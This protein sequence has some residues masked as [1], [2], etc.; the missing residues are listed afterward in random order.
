MGLQSPSTYTSYHL[1]D[2]FFRTFSS[3]RIM[4][5][6]KTCVFSAIVILVISFGDEA[7]SKPMEEGEIS[8]KE[9]MEIDRRRE[10]DAEA[11]PEEGTSLERLKRQESGCLDQPDWECLPGPPL[12]AL[13]EEG[14]S[15]KRLKRLSSDQGTEEDKKLN[16]SR[17]AGF[18]DFFRKLK[19]KLKKA[20]KRLFKRNWFGKYKN[21]LKEKFG[22][23]KA[24]KVAAK[25]LKNLGEAGF[26]ALGTAGLED[27]L[28][29]GDY[30][31]VDAEDGG[32]L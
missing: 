13:T 27:L 25:I 3:R 7:E 18:L 5:N 20:L 26:E 22:S 9:A 17:E 4:K 32:W 29:S 15:L 24:K 6:L 8:S 23:E 2:L 30:D 16:E 12:R 19:R 11:S 14:T 31:N 10:K 21:I 28:A 1:S